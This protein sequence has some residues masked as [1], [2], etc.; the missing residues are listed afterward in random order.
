MQA[1]IFISIFNQ[2]ISYI[3]NDWKS[4]YAELLSNEHWCVMGERIFC[5]AFRNEIWHNPFPVFKE[6]IIA[7]YPWHYQHF[8]KLKYVIEAN[9]NERPQIIAEIIE[10][11][12][13]ESLLTIL[14]QRKTP[15]TITDEN[16]IPPVKERLLESCFEPYNEQICKAARARE[17]HIS[18]NE[19]DTF[20]GGIEGTPEEKEQ[21]TKATVKKIL[22]EKTWWNVFTHYKHDVVYEVRVASG[23]G[24]RW[25]KNE[26]ELIGFLEP[27]I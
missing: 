4:K 18:R 20:W 27:F 15:A 11:A 23:E 21:A 12:P 5:F 17:K 1:E 8:G 24:I 10:E 3:S 22:E 6:E 9:E 25:K 13:I 2:S 14:G 26:L 19:K 16:G 7:D